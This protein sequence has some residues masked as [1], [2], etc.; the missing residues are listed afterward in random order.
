MGLNETFSAI[1]I[2]SQEVDA[3]QGIVEYELL[4]PARNPTMAERRAEGFTWREANLPSRENVR[5]VDLDPDPIGEIGFVRGTL[6]G[7]EIYEVITEV[8]LR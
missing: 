3:E 6:V 1:D 2:V 5:I 8:D 7:I 4:V